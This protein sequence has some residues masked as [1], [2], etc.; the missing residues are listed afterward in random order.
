MSQFG[1]PVSLRD[2]IILCTSAWMVFLL[3][4][5]LSSWLSGR[6]DSLF[7]GPWEVLLALVELISERGFLSDIWSSLRR[8]G[9]SFALATSVALP[10]GLWMGASPKV[11][12]FANALVSP[13]RYLPAPSFVPLLLMW[14]GT[15]DL[16][17]IALL[18]LGVIW[19]LITLFTD[20]TRAVPKE[21]VEASET[22]GA[23]GHML[24]AK[25]IFPGAAPA[26][27]DTIR[28]MLAVS[29]TYLVIAEIVAATDGIGAMMMRAR[30]LLEVDDI[31]AGIAVI[32]LLGFGCDL[33]ARG[34][35]W[36]I[37][38]YLRHQ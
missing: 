38:P 4:W 5:Q 25:V 12:V 34:I 22:L 13:F 1:K 35:R 36:L 19:F 33:L 3:G 14:L 30:R 8:V 6:A 29:W 28:Q 27:F 17:K 15:G 11:G 31:M 18:L 37:F 24:V 2:H 26:Y 20:N 9:I 16:Q 32:G 7:P 21:W 23:Y 10:L